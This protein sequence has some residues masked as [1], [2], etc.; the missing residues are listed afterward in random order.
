MMQCWQ[1]DVLNVIKDYEVIRS[2]NSKPSTGKPLDPPPPCHTSAATHAG[3]T[4]IFSV[5]LLVLC[6]FVLGFMSICPW[7]YAPL[8]L[9]YAPW[10]ILPVAMP[11][12]VPVFV[13]IVAPVVVSLICVALHGP[14]VAL[15]GPCKPDLMGLVLSAHCQ[16]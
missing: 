6:P 3:P 11:I 10:S 12:M 7:L 5:L 13:P 9:S 14:C 16:G 15:H 8:S 2:N 4:D 1:A